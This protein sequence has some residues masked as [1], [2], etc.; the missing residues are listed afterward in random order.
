MLLEVVEQAGWQQ[1]L[2][3]HV[4]QQAPR[5]GILHPFNFHRVIKLSQHAIQIILESFQHMKGSVQGVKADFNCKGK[6][7]SLTLQSLVTYY[8]A[9]LCV[10]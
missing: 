7:V 9:A 5:C 6:R 3:W 2:A 4:K 10:V 1:A 8:F